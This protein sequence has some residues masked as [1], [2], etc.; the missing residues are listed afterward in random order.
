MSSMD[1]VSPVLLVTMAT[2][3]M[4]ELH[5]ECPSNVVTLSQQQPQ[6]FH[7]DMI[8][9]PCKYPLYFGPNRSTQ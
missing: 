2:L 4:N 6:I 1:V 7:R 9:L 5:C 8:T 3:L